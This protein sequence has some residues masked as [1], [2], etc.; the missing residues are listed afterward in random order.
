MQIAIVQ[1]SNAFQCFLNW[2]QIWMV[3]L[4]DSPGAVFF[5]SNWNA[6]QVKL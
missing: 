2:P 1:L 3:S 4:C 6:C 5:G